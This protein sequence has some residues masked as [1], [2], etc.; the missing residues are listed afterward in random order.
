MRSPG[1]ARILPRILLRQP[2]PRRR[3]GGG[4]R[5]GA[6]S[7]AAAV[8][9]YLPLG[10]AAS[11][12]LGAFLLCYALVLACLLPML[13]V[14]RG[15]PPQTAPLL[16]APG[17]GGAAAE[18]EAAAAAA[19]RRFS[20]L[21]GAQLPRASDLVQAGRIVGGELSGL[22]R[23]VMGRIS[24]EYGQLLAEAEAEFEAL[25]QRR[26]TDRDGHR[27]VA[28]AMERERERRGEFGGGAE[29][30]EEEEEG[31]GIVHLPVEGGRIGAHNE[32]MRKK[33]GDGTGRLAAMREAQR[34]AAGT[35]GQEGR[36]GAPA[37]V[38]GAGD[39][40]VA[41][42]NGF[43][44][45]GMHRS[46]TSMLSG[47][48]VKGMGYHVGE[49]LIEPASD[50]EKGF[51]EL[52]PAVEQNDSFM[53]G[54]D[55]WWSSGV[56]N[57][58]AAEALRMKAD[59]EISFREGREALAVL[60]DPSNVPWLQKDPRMCIT[61]GTW[62]PLLDTEPAVVFTYRHP[63]E[64]A[65]S[66]KRREEDFDLAHGLRLWIVYNV[67]AVQNSAGLCRVLSS[68]D[69]ILADPLAEV[70]RIA[71]ELTTKCHVPAPARARL[72]QAAVDD[73]VDR[74][75]QHSKEQR[76][77]ERAQKEVLEVHG[78]CEVY[79][80]DSDHEEGTIQHEREA[81]LY[82]KAME[83]YC[84][85]QSGKAYEEGYDLQTP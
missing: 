8:Q 57:Y 18:A 79:D 68:N 14:S 53:K 82:L 67:R 12:A 64:V 5:G 76:E 63:L 23:R 1:D 29:E 58:D 43:A 3:R 81:Q 51:F 25:R 34:E 20:G 13:A 47:L 84:D 54:Q 33:A 71:D 80:Y 28:G 55:I 6:G 69:A 17:G 21:E 75:L 61:L 26:R 42:R 52:L 35:G 72:T 40:A 2:P 16:R 15:A 38:G 27:A 9:S 7:A 45:L 48:L 44:V 85:L 30:E 83:L 66:L 24:P 31:G 39:P 50:N 62:L 37:V 59:G 22:E 60:G 36:A 32:R 4:G 77:A 11:L 56:V 74:Q 65:L 73:F 46:G 41:V 10:P 49:P 70:Q 19:G 78:E